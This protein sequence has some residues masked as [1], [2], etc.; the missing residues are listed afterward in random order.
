MN[1]LLAKAREWVWL[2]GDPEK[3]QST[4]LA[5]FGAVEI[6]L[7]ILAFALAMFLII[8]TASSGLGGM[9]PAHFRVVTGMLFF[10]TG[11][12]CVTGLG[13][14]KARRWARVL[15]LVGSWV[16]IFLGTLLMALLLYLLPGA[17]DLLADSGILSPSSAMTVLSFSIVL[18]LLLQL[19]LPMVAIG[20]YNLKGVKATCERLNPDPCWSDRCPLPIMAMGFI[21]ILGSLSLLFGASINYIVF[22]FGKVLMGWQ[23]FLIVLPIS[24]VC[25]YIGWGAFMRRMH[26]WWMA[27]A[28]ILLVSASMMLTFSECDMVALYHAMGYRLE[29]IDHLGQVSLLSPALLTFAT[30]V[31]GIMT[32]IYLVL[33]RDSF[34]PEND[35][36]EVKSYR[37]RKA[38]ETAGVP[39]AVPNG[40]R[41]R[42]ED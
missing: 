18:Y 4:G 42:L 15:V 37:Q 1:Q 11:W 14:I 38:E 10:L 19:I 6:I 35:H 2:E 33:V 20:F 3:D 16:A 9:K 13:S 5:V 21:S 27:Y 7:G 29:Q 12:F 36:V 39:D 23:G 32:C 31:W 40:P 34:R 17:Y 41:M 8:L 24:L 26:A 25:G 30:C 28:L 22:L